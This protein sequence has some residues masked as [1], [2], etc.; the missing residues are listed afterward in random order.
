ML[1]DFARDDNN[2]L[3]SDNQKS[4]IF[5]KQ[6]FK[7]LYTGIPKDNWVIVLYLQTIAN[8]CSNSDLGYNKNES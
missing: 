6:T 1:V 5:Q 4:L 7:E 2:K 8:I 3:S